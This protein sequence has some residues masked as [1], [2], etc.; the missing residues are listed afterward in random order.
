[1]S[2]FY[3]SVERDAESARKA[4]IIEIM[5]LMDTHGLSADDLIDSST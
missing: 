1:M 3:A 2:A 4:A 5:G